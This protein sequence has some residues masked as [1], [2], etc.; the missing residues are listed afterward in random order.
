VPKTSGL[1][2]VPGESGH[3]RDLTGKHRVPLG[4]GAE[5]TARRFPPLWVSKRM[6]RSCFIVRQR[7]SSVW[8]APGSVDSILS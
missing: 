5:M 4:A 8:P 2:F 7:R 1:T 6:D 3:V